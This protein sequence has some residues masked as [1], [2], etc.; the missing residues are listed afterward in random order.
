MP[1]FESLSSLSLLRVQ[2]PKEEGLLCP[3]AWTPATHK[4]QD[5]DT[6]SWL[7]SGLDVSLPA[8]DIR[9]VN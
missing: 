2:D 3:G 7:K 8:K 1:D 5:G 9:Q 6:S 4:D